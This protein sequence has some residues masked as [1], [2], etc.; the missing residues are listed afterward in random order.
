[1][2]SNAKVSDEYNLICVIDCGA[3]NF[4]AC[5]DRGALRASLLNIGVKV[6]LQF[7]EFIIES[8]L[9]NLKCG[10]AAETKLIM[11]EF[12]IYIY[13]YIMELTYQIH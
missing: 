11:V 7:F 4:K 10:R 1:M 8:S 5:R 6:F 13:I 2:T 3:V 9:I 12:S